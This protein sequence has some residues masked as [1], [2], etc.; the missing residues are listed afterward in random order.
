M[1]TEKMLTDKG[2]KPT[3]LCERPEKTSQTKSGDE[4]A[5]LQGG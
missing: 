2:E 5:I 1:V 3:V 4:K